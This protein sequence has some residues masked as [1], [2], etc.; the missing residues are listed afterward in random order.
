MS[1]VTDREERER[2]RQ[3]RITGY[4]RDA[5]PLIH[6]LTEAGFDCTGFGSFVNRVTPGVIEP[7]AFDGPGATEILLDWLPWMTNEHVKGSMVRHLRT[8]AAKGTATG[9]LVAE[10]TKSPNPHYKWIVGDVLAFLVTRSQLRRLVPLAAD[11]GHGW[12]RQMLV[13]CLWRVKTPEADAVLLSSLDDPDV[14]RHAM[15]ASRRRFGNRQ[16]RRHIAPLAGHPAE[17]VR[18]AARDCLRRI[19]KRLAGEDS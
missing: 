13:S 3:D 4:R 11:P 12:G 18:R 6:A 8:K 9:A 5:A 17:Q 19:D 7:A 16:A 2:H 14:T 15:S 10:F 1:P